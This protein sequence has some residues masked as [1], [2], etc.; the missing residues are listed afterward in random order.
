MARVDKYHNQAVARGGPYTHN[1]PMDINGSMD[2]NRTL[3]LS[4]P[5]WIV[6]NPANT[7]A[8]I[9]GFILK[10]INGTSIY[11]FLGTGTG[12]RYS[13]AEPTLSDNGTAV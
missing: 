13:A 2:V 6:L 10:T 7:T 1:A 12:M 4:H 11:F 8:A 3:N 9:R 5:N